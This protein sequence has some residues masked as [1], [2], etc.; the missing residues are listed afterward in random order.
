MFELSY[1]SATLVSLALLLLGWLIKNLM[2][3]KSQNEWQPKYQALLKEHG[4]L[5]KKISKEKSLVE[6]LRKKGDSWKQEFQALTQQSN[7]KSKEAKLEQAALREQMTE[8]RS[9]FSTLKIEKDRAD[10]TISKLQKELENL[11]AKYTRD[12]AD[13]KE[14]RRE[15]EIA[16]RQIADLTKKLD[17]QTILAN[18]YQK[19][20]AGQ[21]EEISKIRVMEREKRLMNTKV[22]T[23]EKDV[24][25]WE[26]KH[27][28]THHELAS[29]KKATDS[30]QAKYDD[31]V[32]LR[33]G[34]EILKTNL[35]DQIKEF[36][37]KFVDVNNKYR[38][39]MDS[40]N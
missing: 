17:R 10:T 37:T 6:Q 36:K 39:M 9:D 31:L 5:E 18:D 2:T 4:Q 27:Y 20:Y 7:A 29:L 1:L 11:K 19:K 25:Y 15:R 34:D 30:M 24:T 33:N 21:N 23:L 32:S 35:M 26:K 12:V 3:S 22:K 28:D 38:S 8:V 14:W 40:N 13:G 16:E